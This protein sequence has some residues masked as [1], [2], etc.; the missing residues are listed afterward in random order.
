MNVSALFVDEFGLDGARD[1]N[2]RL[3]S[4]HVADH[5]EDVALELDLAGHH[6][7]D[8]VQLLFDDLLPSSVGSA[9]DEPRLAPLLGGETV[10]KAVALAIRQVH[11]RADVVGYAHVWLGL[12]DE[13]KV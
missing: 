6:A 2:E 7:L 12:D 3:G 4:L 1:G 10:P 9:E 13:T 8:R 5:C 11:P